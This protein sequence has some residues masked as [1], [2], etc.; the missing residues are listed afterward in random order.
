[1]YH[2]FTICMVCIILALVG[3]QSVPMVALPARAGRSPTY[4]RFAY[5]YKIDSS[6][7]KKEGCNV[8]EWG[9]LAGKSFSVTLPLSTVV[10]HQ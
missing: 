8:L 7:K 10:I 4:A 9:A 1:M 3:R 2:C 5:H 6:Q